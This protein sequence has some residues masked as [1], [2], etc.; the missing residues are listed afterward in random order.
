MH[1]VAEKIRWQ[2][3]RE[4]E[5]DEA[6]SYLYELLDGE[7]M[8][9]NYP[10]LKHQQTLVQLLVQFNS[11]VVERKLGQVL[12]APFGVILDE[13]NDVQP[14]LIF[15]SENQKAIVREDGIHGV[16]ELLVEIISPTSVTRDRVRKK[17]VY[18][19]LGVAEY[20]LVDPQNGSIEVYERTDLGYELFSDSETGPVVKS[21]VLAGLEVEAKALFA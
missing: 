4:M 17:A 18:E 9:R 8:K 14:D 21:K 15:V 1:A 3:F 6:D 16:P 5:L 13:F 2:E 20:W 11:F 7:I 10:G 12:P 19:R